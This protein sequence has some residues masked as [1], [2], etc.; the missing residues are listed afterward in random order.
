MQ[1]ATQ[2]GHVIVLSSSELSLD[3]T[4]KITNYND[5]IARPNCEN[6]FKQKRLR[7]FVLLL[8]PVALTKIIIIY[9]IHAIFMQ[10]ILQKTANYILSPRFVSIDC[11]KIFESTLPWALCTMLLTI[12][13]R[14]TPEWQDANTRNRSTKT[15]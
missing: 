12:T 5:K 7:S 9:I 15:K 3:F 1:N 8:R 14:T 13:T 10:T 4:L 2:F 11:T 6:W